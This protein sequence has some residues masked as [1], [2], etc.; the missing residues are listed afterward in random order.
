MTD[1]SAFLDEMTTKFASGFDGFEVY[2]FQG[3]F[4]ELQSAL[5]GWHRPANLHLA[6]VD[7]GGVCEEA[8]TKDEA[9]SL[10]ESELA[11]VSRADGSAIVTVTGLNIL[12]ALYPAGLLQPL[13]QWLR[14]GNRTVVLVVPP[15]PP[16]RLPE[17]ATPTD[18]RSSL[19]NLLGPGR[20]VTIGGA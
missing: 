18:W 6:F 15:P 7:I 1:L 13:N 2:Q 12:F 16:R 5:P 17:S 9:R 3:T 14:K 4:A 10:L 11:R 8:A 20:S 19:T